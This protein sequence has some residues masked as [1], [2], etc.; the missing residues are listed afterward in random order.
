MRRAI[1]GGLFALLLLAGSLPAAA[2]D[3]TQ[4]AA[5]ASPS[6]P[7]DAPEVV[8]EE[9]CEEAEEFTCVTLRMP[10]DHF[11]DTG[12][13]IDVT[14]AVR[15]RDQQGERRSGG[16]TPGTFV[17]L[18]GGPGTSGI[19]YA[20]G[21]TDS[22]E[23]SIRR[24]HDIV[25]LDQRGARL[26]GDL[27]CPDAALA[28]Y[29]TDSDPGTSTA[30]TGL[31]ADAKAFVDACIA[32]SGVDPDILPYLGTRQA[33]E[34]LEAIRQHLGADDLVVYGESYGTQFA[35]GYAA[36]YPD[37]IRGL[38]LDGPVDIS[39][40]LF[41]YYDEQSAAFDEALKATL[42]DCS[43]QRLCAF[44]TRSL[45]GLKAWDD[46]AAQLAEGPGGFEFHGSD[47]RS[48]TREFTA[49]DLTNAATAFL[50]GEYDRMLLQ[51]AVAAAAQGD[52]WYL[53]RLLYTGLVMDPDTQKAI[54]DPS[55]SDGLYYA[56]E[57]LD[58]AI[59]GVTPEERAENYL[60]A[61]RERGV[62]E[63]RLGDVFYGDLPCAF[64]PAQPE[65]AERPEPLTSVPYPM[66]VLGATLDPATPWAN[67][68]RIAEAAGAN[69]RVIV[70][71]GGPH[72]IFGRGEGCPDIPV[73]RFIVH[74]DLPESPRTVCD[75]DVA[76]DYQRLP[77]MEA[78]DDDQY[79]GVL[80]EADREIV[81]SADYWY[82]EAEEPLT[83]GCR[84]GGTVRYTPTDYG[85]RLLLDGCSWRRGAALSGTG[86]IYDDRDEMQMLLAVRPDGTDDP[87][88]PYSRG[89]GHAGFGV[90]RDTEDDIE[91]EV[92]AATRF[93]EGR[94]DDD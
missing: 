70:Q 56:V 68:E 58:Y 74:G 92:E 79:L 14:Y 90:S 5:P 47:G 85:L 61:A 33:V 71:P 38:V 37:R 40:D 55:Y 10:L 65:S 19:S 24:D 7:A 69:A 78:S 13:T 62:D 17:N 80:S 59:P 35:Q 64:W 11:S 6:A 16:A 41:A 3:A 36:A 51:R 28:W 43:I 15:P 84:F 66:L 39:R 22:F 44:D 25:F 12:R 60:A 48:E 2:Q 42:F 89:V 57:C 4:S 27:T 26:S 86:R 18:T 91:E 72:V 20:A 94:E 21:Y 67:A 8:R 83:V 77:R 29:R 49:P 81:T 9:T 30:T 52:L 34:D 88:Q 45:D 82:W 50:Y 31:G 63:R 1:P 73:Q 32:E 53:S 76:D 54:L 75:G 46:L 23:E 87:V 93:L